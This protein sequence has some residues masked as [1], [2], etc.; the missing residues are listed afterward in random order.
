MAKHGKKIIGYR[1]SKTGRFASKATFNRSHAHGGRRF[2]PIREGKARAR[3]GT[4]RKPALPVGVGERGVA[5]IGGGIAPAKKR[6][7]QSIRSLVE[8]YDFEG[9]EYEDVEFQTGIDYG[10]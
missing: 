2:K 1:D 3:K 6:V 5:P 4:K 8:F 7:G 9:Y 10:E